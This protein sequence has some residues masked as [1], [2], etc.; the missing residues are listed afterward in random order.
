MLGFVEF[1]EV[2][3]PASSRLPPLLFGPLEEILSTQG[4]V[5]EA[6]TG[7][8]DGARSGQFAENEERQH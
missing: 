6:A 4:G 2:D 5:G 1:E 7:Q 3:R 8:V